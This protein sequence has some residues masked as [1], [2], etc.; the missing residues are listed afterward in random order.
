MV[1]RTTEEDQ[2]GIKEGSAPPPLL[3]PAQFIRQYEQSHPGASPNVQYSRAIR[4]DDTNPFSVESL[5]KADGQPDFNRKKRPRASSEE[6]VFED[7]WEQLGGGTTVQEAFSKIP[8]LFA[9]LGSVMARERGKN[10]NRWNGFNR[11]QRGHQRGGRG[12]ENNGRGR[13]GRGRGRGR[14]VGGAVDEAVEGGG[15]EATLLIGEIFQCHFLVDV[16]SYSTSRDSATASLRSFS[17]L[18]TFKIKESPHF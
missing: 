8:G 17:C 13:G 15:A 1:D 18:K 6:S 7:P 9:N 5:K 11:F 14:G 2:Q 16:R 3:D 10:K 12:G 4:S